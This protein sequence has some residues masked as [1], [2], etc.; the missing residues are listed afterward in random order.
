MRAVVVTPGVAG[1]LAVAELPEP[2]AD[3]NEA[4]VKVQA[5]SLNRGEVRRAESMPAGSN[6]G[7][8]FAGVVEACARNGEGPAVGSRVVGFSPAMRGW[9]ERVAI[10]A[11]ALAV[12]PDSISIT[13][14]AA[15]PVAGLTALYG[16][17]RGSRLLGAKV[18]VTGASG[19]VGYFAC[20]LA[21]LMGAR[22]VAQVRRQQHVDLVAET[23]VDAVVVDDSGQQIKEH[24]PF[25][26][27]LDGVAGPALGTLMESL[28]VDGQAVLYGVSAGASTE[29]AV[30][31]L[32]AT[33]AGRIDGFHLYRESEIV[34]AGLGLQRLLYLL[35]RGL[36]QPL[37]ERVASWH[38]VGRVAADLI[39]R[40]Y[41][42]KAV[43]TID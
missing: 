16:L 34:S 25:R 27:I 22:V 21:R 7:W 17:E 13:D 41:P 18:L 4:V 9:A 3:S 37:V 1:N 20:Q 19:G 39:D 12:V 23:G 11:R 15:L 33:G 5:V 43:L 26:L 31:Q 8:D 6:I 24:G 30:R 36:L 28:D 10:D 35:E 2:V 42:G 29:L 38:D 32:M 40:A 14:S